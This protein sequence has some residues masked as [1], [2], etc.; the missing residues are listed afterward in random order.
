MAYCCQRQKNSKLFCMI[1]AVITTEQ[2][3]FLVSMSTKMKNVLR[4][5]D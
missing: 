1:R 3:A 5:S 4:D 2:I